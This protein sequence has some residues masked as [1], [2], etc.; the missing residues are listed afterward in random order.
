MVNQIISIVLLTLYGVFDA[1][2]DKSEENRFKNIKLNKSE[3]WKNKWK[4]NEFNEPI[5]EERFIG[6]S[7]FLVFTT[8]FWHFMKWCQLRCIDTSFILLSNL[9][10]YWLIII[11]ILRGIT[12]EL[13]HK[14]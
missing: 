6:S 7:T 8:D 4:K 12:F 2:K 13:I 11:P 3:S 1:L 10:L 5:R 14:K 9:P